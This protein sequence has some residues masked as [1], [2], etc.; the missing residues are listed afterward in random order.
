MRTISKMWRMIYYF[1]FFSLWVTKYIQCNS[2]SIDGSLT[3]INK[4]RDDCY[5]PTNEMCV[6]GNICRNRQH[7]CEVKY[8]ID[9]SETIEPPRLECYDPQSQTCL[10]HTLC[11][12]NRVCNGQCILYEYQRCTYDKKSL[13][14]VTSSFSP[15]PKNGVK[16]CNGLCFNAQQKPYRRCVNEV[17][18]YVANCSGKPYDENYEEC[19][20]GRICSI[21]NTP[22]GTITCCNPYNEVCLN[23]ECCSPSRICGD[24]CISNSYQVCANDNTT[25][26]NVP[27]NNYEPNRMQI[28][29]GSCF[30]T[31]IRTCVNG[32][33]VCI[34]KECNGQ[35]YNPI[36]KICRKNIICNI[37]EDVCEFNNNRYLKEQTTL[38]TSL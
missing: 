26:C 31:S 5:D 34:H 28:C 6:D 20:A 18:E 33:P 12:K 4:C 23:G 9:T 8:D 38:L 27:N 3:C 14:N 15:N 17:L 36:Y 7:V 19:I 16:V 10:N 32:T 11:D 30:D 29:N 2:V 21:G 24:K 22:C 1:G 35:C 25:I 37:N 13:C